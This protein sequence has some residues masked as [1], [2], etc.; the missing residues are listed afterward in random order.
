MIDKIIKAEMEH[1][2]DCVIALQNS[3][4]GRIY[5]SQENKAVEAISKGIAKQEIFVAVDNVGL[6]LGFIWVIRYGAFHS[7]PYLHIIAVKKEFRGMGIGKKLLDYFEKENAQSSKVFLVVADFN[8]SAKLLYE[9]I[10]YREVGV[11]PNLYKNGVVEY[12][13]MKEL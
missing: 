7:F 9:K 11:I 12:L 2:N 13:M 6:C 1:L 3:D 5:F 4:L 8:P 10:G